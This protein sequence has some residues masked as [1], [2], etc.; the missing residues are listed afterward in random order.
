MNATMVLI[1]PPALTDR[2]F[3]N[4]PTNVAVL[5]GALKQ[6]GFNVKSIDLNLEVLKGDQAFFDDSLT[7][8]LRVMENNIQQVDFFGITTL[9]SNYPFILQLAAVLKKRYCKPI[10]LGG[11]QA[12]LTAMR[13][14]ECFPAIDYIV[15]HEGEI[16]LIELLKCLCED[17][18]PMAVR[19]IYFR[20]NGRVLAT[21][22]RPF[23]K[24]LDDSPF[25]DF[26]IVDIKAYQEIYPDVRIPLDTGRGCPFKCTFCS[27]SMMWKRSFRMKSPQRTVAE[28]D[29]LHDQFGVKWF[30]MTQ[31][32]LTTK[33]SYIHELCR[34]LKGKNYTWDCYSR[35]DTLDNEMLDAMSAAG[36]SHIFF[37]IESGSE[38]YQK[39]IKKNLEFRDVK[40]SIKACIEHGVE[41][42]T[43]YIIGFPEEEREDIS[44]T[45]RSCFRDSAH[46]ARS[47]I[48][49]ILAPLQG[50]ELARRYHDRLTDPLA[51]Q[52]DF[53]P[54]LQ[55]NESAA[56]A[57]KMIEAYPDIFS[58]FYFI[59]PTYFDLNELFTIRSF[60]YP[61]IHQFPR[62]T[63][64]IL[65]SSSIQPLDLLD[66]YRKM[67]LS[68]QPTE[69]STETLRRFYTEVID[70]HYD[71]P[72]PTA[73][74]IRELLKYELAIY[75]LRNAPTPKYLHESQ[76]QAA[77]LEVE[78]IDPKSLC[79]SSSLAWR[80]FQVDI[81]KVLE[82]FRFEDYRYELLDSPLEVL[83]YEDA[84]LG[85]LV[86]EI[87][88]PKMKN[89][90]DDLRENKF[91][92]IDTIRK[93]LLILIRKGI[94][95]HHR[96]M[97][98]F[99]TSPDNRIMKKL[100]GN[101]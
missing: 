9:C 24:N 77:T 91:Q 68:L 87:I 13:T 85:D 86:Q 33:K 52:P 35:C 100:E 25:P 44:A 42:T 55:K 40:K 84:V 72:N 73:L 5:S 18:D 7:Q 53:S 2:Y 47:I 94:V 74:L 50:T 46:D 30:F 10:I 70:R 31:D 51:F 38:K 64:L 4:F 32:N 79:F 49:S 67:D 98:I 19:G 20:R 81:S 65:E 11:P 92:N 62:T 61:L 45:L 66:I 8:T 89:L 22:A 69:M 12:T 93:D 58:S 37:G 59:K 41:F 39:V 17:D 57:K 83:F 80:T 88:D 75:Q 29:A 56:K 96:N 15:A 28:M 90:L 27:T 26:G 48:F 76:E 63:H 78:K 43:A 1:S 99:L 16:T 3:L 71:G 95:I 6:A 36:C 60:Y 23:I 82:S 21:P 101:I 14:M 97:G 54:F 34:E